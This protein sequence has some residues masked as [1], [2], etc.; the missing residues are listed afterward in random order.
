MY[1]NCEKININIKNNIMDINLTVVLA[2][3]GELASKIGQKSWELQYRGYRKKYG[4]KTES[5]ILNYLNSKMRPVLDGFFRGDVS[6]LPSGD[7]YQGMKGLSQLFTSLDDERL[8]K[9]LSLMVCMSVSGLDCPKID[10]FLKTC[11]FRKGGMLWKP[12]Q[13]IAN[14]DKNLLFHTIHFWFNDS[15]VNLKERENWA[16]GITKSHLETY[17]G[18]NK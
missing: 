1:S 10:K 5:G 16:Y 11:I 4:D 17:Y 9:R 7:P 14:I 8:L 15:G 12:D 2:E 13:L 6:I 18:L 3:W